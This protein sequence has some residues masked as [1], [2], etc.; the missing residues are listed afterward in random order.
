MARDDEVTLL[1]QTA[2]YALRT[3]L[4]I[5]QRPPGEPAQ[6]DT[7]AS[8][9]RIPRNYLSK[10]LHRLAQEGVLVSTRGRGGG[11]V[12]GRPAEELPLLAI[13]GLFD[14]VEPVRQC[15]LGQPVCSDAH[16]CDAHAKWKD[17][18]DRVAKFFRDTTVADLLGEAQMAA[19]RRARKQKPA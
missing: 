18:S 16:A 4:H 17:V 14:S 3:V 6:T 8:A 7:M 5:A 11:F 12:L 10:I 19:T 1:S 9:L 13:V 15:L 2:E